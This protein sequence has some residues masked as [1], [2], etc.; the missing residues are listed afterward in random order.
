MEKAPK[1][2]R[3][4]CDLTCREANFPSV[5]AVDGAGSCRTFS[6][7]YCNKLKRLVVK[8]APCQANKK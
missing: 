2:K 7:L 6:A 8:N 5:E 3:K 1:N 4:W